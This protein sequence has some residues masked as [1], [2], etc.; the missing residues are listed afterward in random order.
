MPTLSM[1]S[2]GS[3]AS[4]LPTL[5][6]AKAMF[7]VEETEI[8]TSMTTKTETMAT[9][10]TPPRMICVLKE[11]HRTQDSVDVGLPFEGRWR[12]RWMRR[13]T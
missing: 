3:T 7:I 6:P 8:R 1:L 5:T 2:M 12:G 13:M 9:D 10:S 11:M 4:A